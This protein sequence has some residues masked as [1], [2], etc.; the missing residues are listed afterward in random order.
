MV[1]HPNE[2]LW[3][4]GIGLHVCIQTYTHLA[5]W[6]HHKQLVDVVGEC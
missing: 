5:K 4:L 2:W 1:I 3:S 6:A